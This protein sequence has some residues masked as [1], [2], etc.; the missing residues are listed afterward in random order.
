[1]MQGIMETIFDIFYL[2]FD[3]VIGIKMIRSSDR[4][5]EFF[6]YG[7]MAIVLGAGDAFHLYD[8]GRFQARAGA[9]PILAGSDVASLRDW[10]GLRSRRAPDLAGE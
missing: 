5:S 4:K 7:I 6:L 2:G 1:M 10:Q 8:G 3:L 9:K